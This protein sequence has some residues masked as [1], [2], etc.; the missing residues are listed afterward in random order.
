MIWIVSS[1]GRRRLCG[2][3]RSLSSSQRVRLWWSAGCSGLLA[4]WYMYSVDCRGLLIPGPVGVRVLLRKR[5]LDA[6]RR[7]M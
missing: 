3:W 6:Y 4:V 7:T 2:L 5:Y 1:T